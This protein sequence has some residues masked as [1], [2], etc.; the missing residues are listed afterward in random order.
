MNLDEVIRL[1]DR[2]EQSSFTEFALKER[3]F[4]LRLNRAE[5]DA[6]PAPAAKPAAPKTVSASPRI[7]IE[8]PAK[9]EAEEPISGNVM[10]APIVGVFYSKSSPEAEPYVKVGQQ[11][12]KGD[13]LFIIE[14]MKLFNEVNSEYDGTVKAILCQDGDMV[15]YGQPVVVIE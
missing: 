3:D 11:V 4:E 6:A 12:K 5:G 7:T 1:I 14:A 8:Q 13:V 15:Q 9:E 2:I 10:K